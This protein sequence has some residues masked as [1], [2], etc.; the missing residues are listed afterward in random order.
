[1]S[2]YNKYLK[3]GPQ[4]QTSSQIKKI[5]EKVT[6]KNT[7]I[8]AKI[9]AIIKFIHKNLNHERNKEKRKKLLRA[10]TANEILKSKR[11]TGCGDC[12]TVFISL[13]RELGI[14]CKWVDTIAEDWLEEEKLLEN[15]IHGHIF[16]DVLINN[17]W[18]VLDPSFATIGNRYQ[19]PKLN[20]QIQFIV[21]KKG[22]DAWDIGIGSLDDLRKHY[23]AFKKRYRKKKC[24]N[25]T[26][27]GF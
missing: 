2:K 10:R 1:M 25:L 16:V 7:T 17:K 12:A 26:N 22:L 8:L 23:L 13:A 4:T 21:Y 14:P 19:W 20:G 11:H 18:Y 27:F 5:A 6:K 9:F 24:R 3:S 15:Q